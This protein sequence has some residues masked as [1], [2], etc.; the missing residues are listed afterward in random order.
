M[1]DG[2]CLSDPVRLQRA[3]G[4]LR[5]GVK[6]SGERTV[7][8]DLR[9]AGCLK[10]RFPRRVEPGWMDIVTLNTGGGVAAADRLDVAVAAGEGTQATVAAQA[11]E[12]FYRA[13]PQDAPSHVRT[14]LTLAAGAAL[15]WL[16]QETI[17]FDRSALDRRL[18]IDMAADARFLGVETLVFGRAAMGEA[19][20]H[21]HLRDL[22]RIRRDGALLLHDT[23]RMDGAVDDLLHRA[24][25]GQGA[26]ALA[27]LVYVAPDA[28]AALDP[29]RQ[30]LQRAA[31][32]SGR[33][34]G[35]PSS[36]WPAQAGGSG[37]G[38]GAPLASWPA[39]AGHSR[40][41]VPIPAEGVDA[42]PAPGMTIGAGGLSVTDVPA[43][44]DVP[45]DPRFAPG[46]AE[47]GAS[48]WNGM[49]VARILGPDGAPV[50]RAVVAV[51]AALR[52][53][54]PLPRVWL[55]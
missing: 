32:G 29:V 22:I 37:R 10:A 7:L 38:G 2:A 36:S 51:L 46:S 50:R 44:N 8:D 43:W 54:R 53:S 5:V 16:P 27:T 4:E 14:R 11:A 21:A 47:A 26:R 3:V 52:P 12:R 40:L 33:A 20:R 19:V 41:A 55:C 42:G 48:A 28:E 45:T 13:L 17:L 35:A 6:R 23:I 18:E 39:Q 49:L 34:G 31:D 24:A 25:I 9:Q 1:Y 30:A 15:E